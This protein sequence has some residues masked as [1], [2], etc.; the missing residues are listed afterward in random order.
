MEEVR[1]QLTRCCDKVIVMFR[2]ERSAVHRGLKR[3]GG[4][5]RVRVQVLLL[6][7][8]VQER[9][10]LLE[11]RLPRREEHRA[12]NVEPNP[13]P[14]VPPVRVDNRAVTDALRRR[15]AGFCRA[16]GRGRALSR[17]AVFV[18]IVVVVIVVAVVVVAA[19]VCWQCSGVRRFPLVLCRRCH[20]GKKAFGHGLDASAEVPGLLPR[21]FLPAIQPS[22]LRPQSAHSKSTLVKLQEVNH[23]M[24]QMHFQSKSCNGCYRR[25]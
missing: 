7:Q 12:A 16:G 25:K 3:P 2:P 20:L 23:T 18:V 21:R 24:S 5:Y 4:A 8:P 6:A 15:P 11:E 14:V 22:M 13:L 9:S 1:S 19:V 17:L 10:L